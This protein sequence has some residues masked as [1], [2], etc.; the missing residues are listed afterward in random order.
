MGRASAVVR[1]C[2][3]ATPSLDAC[4]APRA[5]SNVFASKI[6][7]FPDR[8]QVAPLYEIVAT[9]PGRAVADAR[10]EEVV[11]RGR[12]AFEEVLGASQLGASHA[13]VYGTLDLP[14]VAGDDRHGIFRLLMAP[15]GGVPPPAVLA[16]SFGTAYLATGALDEVEVVRISHRRHDDLAHAL[17]RTFLAGERPGEGV[18][19]LQC[20][21][22]SR[23][24]GPWR[25]TGRR[26]PAPCAVAVG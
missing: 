12:L 6:L 26:D 17:A 22:T 8:T 24:P 10:D 18:L 25:W 3:G 13:A 7:H 4:G 19:A 20:P 21:G 2:A 14:G 16:R 5:G 15:A 1:A 9:L 11:G 23:R